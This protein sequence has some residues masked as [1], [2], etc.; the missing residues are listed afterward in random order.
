VL[1]VY[2]D[3]YG[4]PPESTLLAIRA[5]SFNLGEAPTPEAITDLQRALIW[6]RR[7]LTDTHTP[8]PISGV[9]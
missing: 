3:L 9:D 1:Q 4:E 6:A 2:Q 8:P 7:W 5:R